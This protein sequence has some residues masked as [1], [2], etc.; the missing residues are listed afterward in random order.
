[1]VVEDD[2]SIRNGVAQLLEKGGY[3]VI[4]VENGAQAIHTIG[5]GENPLVV[6]VIITDIDNPKGM[7]AISYFKR[8]HPRVSIIALTGLEDPQ[9]GQQEKTRVV[10]L[11]AGKGGSAFLDLL[12]HLPGIEIVGIAD[13][14]TSAPG[15]T[16]ARELGIPVW[17]DIEGLIAQDGVNLIID[18][19]GDP[20]MVQAI[21][22]N[23]KEGVE[24]LGGAASRLLWNV[25][26][27]EGQMQGHLLQTEKVSNLMKAGMILDYLVKPVDESKINTAVIQAMEQ[28]EIAK[29]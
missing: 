24:M 9:A 22:K 16:R 6:D 27:Y 17:D 18:V 8:Q 14:M 13:K 20:G 19:T 7:E 26:Q 12:S 1:M 5:E 25:V 23:K 4:E 2:H 21:W 15:L 11:G 10:I 3:D 28:R 29:L